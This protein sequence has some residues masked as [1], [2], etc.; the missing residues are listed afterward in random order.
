MPLWAIRAGD[1]LE[2]GLPLTSSAPAPACMIVAKAVSNSCAIAAFTSVSCQKEAS[3]RGSGS[4]RY[5]CR[6]SN[7]TIS[8]LSL[9]SSPWSAGNRT[10]KVFY[11]ERTQLR[12]DMRL[13][14]SSCRTCC[15]TNYTS[16]CRIVRHNDRRIGGVSSYPPATVQRDFVEVAASPRADLI[17]APGAGRTSEGDRSHEKRCDRRCQSERRR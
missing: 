4:S 2:N 17:V 1:D 13:C 7:S 8:N 9:S 3:G 5:P 16:P 14:M 12:G 15:P 6:L 11:L 10:S